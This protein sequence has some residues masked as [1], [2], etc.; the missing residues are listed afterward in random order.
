MLG[1]VFSPW[2][3]AARRRGPADPENYCALNVA[4]YGAGG[5][6]W[7]LTDRPRRALARDA[8]RLTIGPSSLAWHGN[9]LCVTIRERRMPVP[10][11]IAGEVRVTFDALCRESFALDPRGRHAWCPLAACARIEV[12]FTRPRRRWSGHAYLD[13]NAGIAP[14]EQDFSGWHWSRAALPD[15]AAVLYDAA[16]RDGSRTQLALRL[17]AAGRVVPFTPPAIQAL[18]STLWRIRRATRSEVPARVVGTLEDTPFYARSWLAAR[19]L[20]HEVRAFHES[21]DL[22]RFAARWVQA[23]LPFRM[24]RQVF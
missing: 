12:E 2:Y 5:K 20:G 16:C 24:A 18:P 21:L 10:A 23:L 3:A 14:L 9:S 13:T 6:R 17:D 15:G 7:A 11:A 22:D 4:L 1:N 8:G 19:L